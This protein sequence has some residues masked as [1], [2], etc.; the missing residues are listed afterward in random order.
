MKANMHAPYSATLETAWLPS[1]ILSGLAAHS[2]ETTSMASGL[3]MS[4]R[5]RRGCPMRMSCRSWPSSMPAGM[6]MLLEHRLPSR[7]VVW[8]CGLIDLPYLWCI[9]PGRE[10][11]LGPDK[12]PAASA[13]VLWAMCS[14][15][16]V[17]QYMLKDGF[18]M[19]TPF[20]CPALHVISQLA[21]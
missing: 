3:A 7:W 17:S 20:P 2:D 13:D 16:A 11:T 4:F 19:P 12:R 8:R 5:M 15:R 10:A 18:L 9:S 14:G 6:R 21:M 1:A